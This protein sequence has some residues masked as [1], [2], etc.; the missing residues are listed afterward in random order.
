M[1]AVAVFVAATRASSIFFF[2]F[3]KKNWISAF[4]PLCLREDFI[5]SIQGNHR[6]FN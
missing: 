2:D 3:R 1:L 6:G 4:Y 5:I